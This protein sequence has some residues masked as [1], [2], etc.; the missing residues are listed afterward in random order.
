M[1]DRPH[2]PDARACSPVTGNAA[3][4][5]PR[6][7]RRA[8]S[9]SVDCLRRWAGPRASTSPLVPSDYD[10][11]PACRMPPEGNTTEPAYQS[12][13]DDTCTRNRQAP[14]SALGVPTECSGTTAA[15][16]LR[17]SARTRLAVARPAGSCRLTGS[18]GM[19][20]SAGRV[21]PV[22]TGAN[23][24]RGVASAVT[25]AAPTGPF[26]RAEH[27]IDVGHIRP[28]ADERLTDDHQAHPPSSST[29]WHQAWSRPRRSWRVTH[30]YTIPGQVGKTSDRG[31]ELGRARDHAQC[32]QL[33]TGPVLRTGIL[34]RVPN[35][36]AAL[37]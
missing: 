9:A 35:P 30:V 34:L 33:S 19:G 37:A 21:A 5:R 3:A 10:D 13:V 25:H 11:R 7:G 27:S 32:R 6:S 14:Y 8:A 23:P 28:R 15:F 17:S 22:A 18:S 24:A 29:G 20:S 31:I 12:A 1:P 36:C 4:H 26:P 2:N 16:T